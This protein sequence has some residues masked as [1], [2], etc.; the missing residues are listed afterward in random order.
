MRRGKRIIIDLLLWIVSFS[1]KKLFFVVCIF[2]WLLLTFAYFCLFT[3]IS[4]VRQFLI[5]YIIVRSC[6][7][8]F[9]WAKWNSVGD[10]A[11]CSLVR[12]RRF[13]VD[14]FIFVLTTFSSASK[15][16]RE[17]FEKRDRNRWKSNYKNMAT[18][19]TKETCLAL[20]LY[21]KLRDDL[22]SKDHGF[23][24]PCVRQRYPPAV[25]AEQNRYR[26]RDFLCGG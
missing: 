16:D 14:V 7:V 18:F 2:R 25:A 1:H 6:Y 19:Q 22:R 9:H 12:F 3:F 10:R 26:Y 24:T 20:V 13:A 11:R 21:S 5:V 23:Q 15:S 4:S 8:H 17:F